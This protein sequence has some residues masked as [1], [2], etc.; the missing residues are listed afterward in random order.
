MCAAPLP[1]AWGSYNRYFFRNRD[2]RKL[3]NDGNA[4]TGGA[5]GAIAGLGGMATEVRVYAP[6][7]SVPAT[8]QS[9]PISP[10]QTY[11]R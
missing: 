6:A 4:G 7:S 9:L 10:N 1:D 11:V 2:P 5:N 3:A 8:N